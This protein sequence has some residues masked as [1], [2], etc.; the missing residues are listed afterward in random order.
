MSS[1]YS[2]V[3]LRVKAETDFG[4]AVHIAGSAVTMGSFNLTEV[5]GLEVEPW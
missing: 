3:Y 5:R 4:Q 2:T 1:Q